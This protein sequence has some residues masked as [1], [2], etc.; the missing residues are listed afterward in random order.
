MSLPYHW[1]P[2]LEDRFLETLTATGSVRKAAHAVGM[3]PKSAYARRR[4]DAA[5]AA[6]WQR[7]LAIL[8]A[9]MTD[10]LLSAAID[11]YDC[12]GVR[13][14]VTKRLS[15]RRSDPVLGPGRGLSLFNRLDRT[16]TSQG[17]YTDLVLPSAEIRAFIEGLDAGFV[18]QVNAAIARGSS[19]PRG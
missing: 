8:V 12:H 10:V 1:T 11:G 9:R 3:A 17:C 14:P 16:L 18:A 13:H 5:F 15:W 19:P 4:R 6:R 2:E 7:A